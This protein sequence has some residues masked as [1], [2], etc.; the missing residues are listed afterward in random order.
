[1]NDPDAVRLVER[2][3]AAWNEPQ[4]EP[5][6]VA[7]RALW[8]PDGAVINSRFEYR[9]H[10][11]VVEAITRSYERFVAAGYRYRARPETTAHHR[12]VCVLWQM[13]DPQG[14]VDSFGANFLLLNQEARIRLD[15]QFVEA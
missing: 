8:A 3:I 15:Y 7:A 1:M 10:D 5:R 6:A 11:R 12:G 13:L 14:A 4:P 9:G 2:Y